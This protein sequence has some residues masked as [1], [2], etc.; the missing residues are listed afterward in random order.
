MKSSRGEGWIA[1]LGITGKVRPVVV[2]SRYDSNPPRDLVI[3]V[4]CTSQNRQSRYEIDISS[5]PFL[6]PNSTAN[7]QGIG[8]VPTARLERKLGKLS[9]SLLK[10]IK[11]ALKFAVDLD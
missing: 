2:I 7:V 10:E 11:D 1:D 3:Y 5:A 6:S 9:D 8:S 4:P